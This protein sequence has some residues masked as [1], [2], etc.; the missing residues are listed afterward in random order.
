[1]LL[2]SLLSPK[3][4]ELSS[5]SYPSHGCLAIDSDDGSFVKA[6][7]NINQN[8]NLDCKENSQF[9]YLYVLIDTGNRARSCIDEKVF[10][11]ISPEGSVEPVKT[12]LTTASNGQKLDVLGRTKDYIELKF[13][14]PKNQDNILYKVRPMVVRNLSLPFVLSL[15]DLKKLR[16]EI[17]PHLE[18]VLFSANS[19][20]VE[21]KMSP[22]PGRSYPV[23]TKKRITIP[24]NTEMVCA[25]EVQNALHLNNKDLVFNPGDKLD[26][27]G[28]IS[29]A[30]LCRVRKKNPDIYMRVMNCAAHPITLKKNC[31]VGNAQLWGYEGF[32]WKSGVVGLI[33]EEKEPKTVT[34]SM[35]RQ[36]LFRELYQQLGF[37]KHDSALKESEKRDIVRLF[38]SHRNALALEPED[39]GHTD[40]VRIQIDTGDAK[41]IRVKCRP[42]PP[43]LLEA[44]KLQIQKWLSQKVISPS[45]GPWASPL[46][47]VRKPN[48]TYRFA[49]DYRALNLV[50]RKD[51]RPVANMSEKLRNLR[52]SPDK[53]YKYWAT[54]D[55]SEAYHCVEVDPADRDKTAMITPLGLYAFNR[56]SFGLAAAPQAFH[57]VVQLIE[58]G[59]FE[60]NPELSKSILMYFDDAILGGTSF[61]DLIAK[62]E[63][64]I[65]QIEELGLRIGPKKC[66]IGC[67]ELTWLGHRIS[68]RG[69]RPDQDRVQTLIDWPE[70]TNASEVKAIHGL[71]SYFRKFIREFSAK[72]CNMRELMKTKNNHKTFAWTAAHKAEF[73]QLIEELTGPNI[74]GHPD[75]SEEAEPFILSV[76]TSKL[77]VGAIL[78]QYQT[79][80]SE[81]GKMLRR[82][83]LIAYASRSLTTG[84]RCYS[85]YKLEL[86]GLVSSVNHFKYFL[87]GK[88]FK[89]KT[90][91][92]AL[93]WLMQTQH[94]ECPSIVFRWQQA[95][96]DYSFDIEYVPASKMKA[97]DGLSRKGYKLGDLGVMEAPTHK[98]E[99]LW[100]SEIEDS[101][102][103]KVR[104]D[105]DFWIPICKKKFNPETDR[106]NPNVVAIVTR[107]RAN[108]VEDNQNS[109]DGKVSTENS[110]NFNSSDSSDDQDNQSDKEIS[111]VPNPKNS[112]DSTELE[113][114]CP[115]LTKEE[116]LKEISKGFSISLSEESG[117]SETE[118]EEK[119]SSF[120]SYLLHFQKEDVAIRHIHD[121]IEGKYTW[122]SDYE[123]IRSR[124]I[125]LFNKLSI[126]KSVQVPDA[127]FRQQMQLIYLFRRKDRLMVNAN[128]VLMIKNLDN[129]RKLY[130][131]PLAIRKLILHVIHKSANHLGINKTQTL[132]DQYI[133][134]HNLSGELA[135]LINSCAQCQDAKKLENR[136]TPGLGSTTSQVSDRLKRWSMDCVAMPEGHGGNKYLLTL[137]DIS[138][139][140]FECFA[141]RNATSK[142]ILAKILEHIIPRYGEGQIF[143]TDRGT[144]FTSKLMAKTLKDNGCLLYVGCPYW[145]NSTAVERAH[146]TLLNL[147]RIILRDN[148]WPKEKW[149]LTL[150]ECLRT[151]RMCPGHKTSDSPFSRVFGKEPI[152]RTESLLSPLLPNVPDTTLDPYPSHD[153][154]P[155]I[156]SEIVSETENQVV[157]KQN[158]ETRVLNKCPKN[159]QMLIQHISN[160]NEIPTQELY[161]IRKDQIAQNTHQRNAERYQ[162]GKTLYVPLEKELV[163]Y[164]RPLDPESKS[165]RKLAFLW[166]GPFL[167][168]KVHEGGKTVDIVKVDPISMATMA[169]EKKS[170]KVHI[171]QVR[172]SLIL[173]FSN[174]LKLNEKAP[175]EK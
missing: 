16:A 139:G 52:S 97:A 39:V 106:I 90:D 19:N 27:S 152:L 126:G 172:P 164:M 160:I 98:R 26:N 73:K 163:D 142:I 1:M 67:R 143:M 95:L 57:A 62:L 131:I 68:E 117:L 5:D 128:G 161:Q 43:H 21:V 58:K 25:V 47:P 94:Q 104:E 63:L 144:E 72:T 34:R 147:I 101:K 41:P 111:D 149:P 84:E 89:V 93:K 151:M 54:L 154:Q 140:W 55:L 148:E 137:L 50:T 64:F 118:T 107:S 145:P 75:F 138:T 77:G 124:L 108:V 46:V 69:I 79:L 146:R 53:P 78:S 109:S 153:D 71:A 51:A 103:A 29:S 96:Q 38:A 155:K 74:L 171:S 33:H 28:L 122:P 157:V 7:I 56:M 110:D 150:S 6:K 18:S 125:K 116:L 37:D 129:N 102:D 82:E 2:K 170:R 165:S 60:K 42:L 135:E 36:S 3:S 8:P 59:L 112:G 40:K 48:G 20:N 121:C 65:T 14:N 174:R 134:F 92:K 166:T 80:K 32:Q 76:D 9:K 115:E 13:Y 91:H 120:E 99:P 31:Q 136:Q 81:S 175:W 10:K 119:G 169:T 86:A 22:L 11:G 173:A 17:K 130:V 30:T 70:P 141:V 114:D 49:V 162:K 66:K 168:T 83:V 45:N 159:S 123:A 88:R 158:Q 4:E 156:E 12:I 127:M 35:T 15:Y 61:E 100:H 23:S 85:S 24:A 132:A 44:L 105:D 87:M 113:L 133:S 167:V